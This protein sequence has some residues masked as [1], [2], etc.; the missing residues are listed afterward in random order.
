[1]AT[2][3]GGTVHQLPETPDD[4]LALSRQGPDM[5]QGTLR[6]GTIWRGDAQLL[7]SLPQ[8]E[9]RLATLQ[10]RERVAQAKAKAKVKAKAEEE[11]PRDKEEPAESSASWRGGGEHGEAGAPDHGGSA[12]LHGA[13]AKRQR[14]LRQIFLSSGSGQVGGEHGQAGALEHGGGEHDEAGAPHDDGG[15]RVESGAAEHCDGI[16]VDEHPATT[17]TELF[18]HDREEDRVLL[19]WL[20]ERSEHLRCSALLE[21]I[22]EWAGICRREEMRSLAKAQGIT[23]RRQE[24]ADVQK[25][26]EAARRHFKAAVGQ[27]K[28]R[29]ACFH[30]SA[31]R[32]ASEHS[33]SLA[34]EA[35]HVLTAA[36]VVDLRTLLLFRRQQKA[37]MP[38]HLREAIGR[39]G[40]GYRANNQ[41]LRDA[42]K[43][44]GMSVQTRVQYPGGDKTSRGSRKVQLTDALR[45]TM[46]R[47]NCF[48]RVRAWATTNPVLQSTSLST[49]QTV[50]E[51]AY[52]L[53]DPN[54]KL[55]CP[56]GT[57]FEEQDRTGT[58]MDGSHRI[59]FWLALVELHS[60]GYR[61]GSQSDKH[62]PHVFEQVVDVLVNK[63][64]DRFQGA[65]EHLIG[66]SSDLACAFMT[67]SVSDTKSRLTIF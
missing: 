21:Q 11:P 7:R 35:E 48:R 20:R 3:A 5:Y 12:E 56:F 32:G 66:V 64:R 18:V 50:L 2:H 65:S 14:T 47:N 53:R 43:L 57:D 40:G 34:R 27:E 29:L 42:A 25:L 17:S 36:E 62:L 39:L 33:D 15:E 63:R 22:M 38:D 24:R 60:D 54:G 41:N 30:L 28:G 23:I 67:D 6:S 61:Y 59:P 9:A 44:L 26:R 31:T 1:M 37:D 55:R 10:T 52:M 4:V 13:S 46:L 8:G 16:E 58:R 45:M 19:D 51:L 49:P